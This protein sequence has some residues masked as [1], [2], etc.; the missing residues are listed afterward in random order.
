MDQSDIN[1][2]LRAIEQMVDWG[3]SE[4]WTNQDFELLGEEIYAKTHVHL[5]ITT[6]KRIWGKVDY[7]SK[8]STSTFRR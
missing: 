2:C 4:L 7:Q 1:F 5:S 6:L 3:S 8:P